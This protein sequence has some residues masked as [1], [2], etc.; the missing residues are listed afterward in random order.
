M[1]EQPKMTIEQV[2]QTSGF[3]NA[4]SFRR[5]FKAKFGISPSEFRGTKE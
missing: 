1:N 4:V 5:S 2:S 3:S